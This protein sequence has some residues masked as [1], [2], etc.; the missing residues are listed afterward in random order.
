MKILSYRHGIENSIK[1]FTFPFLQN[2][3]SHFSLLFDPAD[4]IA[5][6]LTGK[7]FLMPE[8]GTSSPSG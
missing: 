5:R 6:R 8:S 2:D 4:K 3:I 1:N 7:K